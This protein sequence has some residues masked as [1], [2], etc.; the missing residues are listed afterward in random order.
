MEGGL[1][2]TGSTIEAAGSTW[3]LIATA[4]G[5]LNPELLIFCHNASVKNLGRLFR[6]TA[7]G[8]LAWFGLQ[9]CSTLEGQLAPTLAGGV[10]VPPGISSTSEPFP[11]GWRLLN[12]FGPG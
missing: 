10:P 12:F 6:W 9:A 11:Q 7:V 8:I 5:L 3:V 2:S 1:D 4:S